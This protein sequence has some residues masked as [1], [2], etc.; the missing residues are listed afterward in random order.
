MVNDNETSAG[1]NVQVLN[2]IGQT[3]ALTSLTIPANSQVSRYVSELAPQIVGMN[4]VGGVTMKV[5]STNVLNSI[6]VKART[7]VGGVYSI[8]TA[9]VF[10]V[11]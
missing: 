10:A 6:A 11:N 5:T 8:S 3:I 2:S 1:V 9:D 7:T 4:I